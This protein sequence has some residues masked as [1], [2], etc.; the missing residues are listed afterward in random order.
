MMVFQQ[1]WTVDTR[2]KGPVELT[3]RLNRLCGRSGVECG[4]VSLFCRH[5][6]CGLV[7]M[8]NADP[9]A[10]R[11]LER[12]FDRLVPEDDADFVHTLEGS[13]DMPA[14]I[15]MAL[16]RSSETIPVAGGKP[17]LGTWQGVFLWEFRSRPHQRKLV[18]TVMGEPGSRYAAEVR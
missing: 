6:S 14:H 7:L 13:D 10:W 18:V 11:D 16:V 2:G 8:E 17:Q 5:T 9:S 4:L 1:T 12:W 15:K 3:G